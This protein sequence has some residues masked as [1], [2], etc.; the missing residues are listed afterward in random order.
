MGLVVSEIFHSIQGESTYAGRPC[1]FVRMSGCNLRCAWCDTAYAWENGRTM[2]QDEVILALKS[3]GCQ[4]VELTGG[5]PLM[6]P[7]M[8]E[9]ARKLVEMGREVLVETN[10]TFPVDILD[11]RVTAIVDIKSPSSGMS[12]RTLWKNLEML[13]PKDELKFVI[14]SREDFD[15]AASVVERL[16]GESP[17]SEGRIHFSPVLDRLAPSDLAAWILASRL[18]VRLSLQLHKFIWSPDARGV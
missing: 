10:G 15:Y 17:L 6:Q 4:L 7:E 13:R 2:S 5:E 3:F 12:A 1:A 11:E 16:P 14:A 18:P 9:L 8:P